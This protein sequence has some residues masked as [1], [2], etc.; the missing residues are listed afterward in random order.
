M[1]LMNYLSNTIVSELTY[2]LN[3]PFF[4]WKINLIFPTNNQ[5]VT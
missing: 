1:K 2:K 5:K 4:L 3:R